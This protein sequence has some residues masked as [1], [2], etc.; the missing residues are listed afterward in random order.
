WRTTPLATKACP[1]R[2]TVRWELLVMRAVAELRRTEGGQRCARE[3]GVASSRCLGWRSS[4]CGTIEHTSGSSGLWSGLPGKTW[5]SCSLTRLVAQST[6]PTS[7]SIGS[8]P[9]IYPLLERGGVARLQ[10]SRQ[11]LV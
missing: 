11:H 1:S 7:S 3:A 8:I 5:T 10:A 9:W 4:H 6:P 2:E